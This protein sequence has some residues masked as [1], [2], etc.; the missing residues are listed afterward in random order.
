[1]SSEQMI[2]QVIREMR[3]AATDGDDP[4]FHVGI[5][6][7]QWADRLSTPTASMVAQFDGR[8][9]PNVRGG[10][11][12]WSDYCQLQ[13]RLTALLDGIEGLENQLRAFD[14]LTDSANV[15]DDLKALREKAK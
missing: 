12:A 5:Q 6:L 9:N 14:A 15:A 1:M 7:Q 3:D 11:V 13:D 8:G 10:W 2:A 4:Q